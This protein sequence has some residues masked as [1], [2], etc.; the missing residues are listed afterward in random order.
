MQWYE[1]DNGDRQNLLQNTFESIKE[2][3]KS[4]SEANR[5]ALSLYS[6]LNIADDNSV[7]FH[8]RAFDRLQTVSTYNASRQITDTLISKIGKNRPRARIIPSKA[9]F[10]VKDEAKKLEQF[11][12]GLFQSNGV[13][14]ISKDEVLPNS[15]IYGTGIW[16]IFP[17]QGN[18]RVE[19]VSPNNV[20]IDEREGRNK[21]PRQLFQ[22]SYISK[23]LLLEEYPKFKDAI[24]RATNSHSNNRTTSGNNYDEVEVVEAWHL[25]SG[26]DA[27]DGLYCIFIKEQLLYEAEYKY[28]FFPH[29]FFRWA[30]IPNYFWGQGVIEMLM[31]LQLKLNEI[32]DSID[33]ALEFCV[34]WVLS[35]KNNEVN[36]DHIGNE[37]M[38]ILQYAAGTQPPVVVPQN[39]VPQQL[40]QE[41][42]ATYRK[43]FE[44]IGVSELSANARKPSGL[45]SGVALQEFNDIE[46]ERFM[47]QLQSWETAH[48]EIAK[49]LI[50]CG[51]SISEDKNYKDLRVSVYGEKYF[52]SINWKDVELK[53]D[54]Y[55][56]SIQ[57]ASIFPTTPAGKIQ[58]VTDLL[59]AGLVEQ[60]EARELLLDTPDLERFME[61]DNA[62]RDIIKKIVDKMS[63]DGVYVPPQPFD[64]LEYAHKY[65]IN[66][67]HAIRIEDA[68]EENLEV[69]R[70]YISAC[71]A[72]MQQ[73]EQEVMAQ[74]QA[75]MQAQ[76]PAMP[77]QPVQS[78]P[79]EP[80]ANPNQ[81]Q[82]SDLLPV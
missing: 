42:D 44:L 19:S 33:Q 26:P 54:L 59:Q 79:A 30:N 1:K 48:M 43:C 15:L 27:K 71:Q 67:Y 34:P 73:A 45:N 82:V 40:F 12:L 65:A 7:D 70:N 76:Q 21:K 39:P 9:K 16:K 69:I 18:C 51:K 22:T 31:P 46:S 41:R 61:L 78:G 72:M 28:D 56:V 35:E 80:L 3:S 17:Y 5:D 68:P 57:P 62:H 49:R 50:E 58:K 74:Q 32:S 6:G 23:D 81:P 29:V 38:L 2:D 60:A 66:V 25:S 63:V 10:S 75:Q 24:D 14:N 37:N 77:Q 55:Q 4:L 52:E 64:N 11:V 13:F 8:S 20:Y 36:L 53:E 47:A